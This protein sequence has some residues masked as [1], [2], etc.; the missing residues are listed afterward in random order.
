MG[1]PI[2]SRCGYRCDLCMA[3]KP[4]IDSNPKNGEKLSDGWFKYFGF[5]IPPEDIICDGCM[6]ENPRLIDQSCQVR[7]CVIDKGFNHCG[8]CTDYGCSKL[9]D[10]WVVYEDIQSKQNDVISEIDRT[11]FIFPYEN[12]ARLDLMRKS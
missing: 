7:M 5:R 4:N 3:Y 11:Q 2:L 9:M 10:R 8:E 1:E 12:K 6:A